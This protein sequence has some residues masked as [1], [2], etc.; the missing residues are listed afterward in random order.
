MSRLTQTENA[1][2]RLSSEAQEL[3]DWVRRSTRG[4]GI[5][6]KVVDLPTISSL[7]ALVTVARTTEIR[8]G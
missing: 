1:P 5:S 8:R 6:E 7:H 2:H 3:A 4:Q